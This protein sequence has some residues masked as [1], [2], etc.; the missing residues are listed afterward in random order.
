M[1]AKTYGALLIALGLI[2]GSG[3]TPSF[4]QAPAEACY[5]TPVPAECAEPLLKELLS[6]IDS[7]QDDDKEEP[8]YA[9]IDKLI[10]HGYLDSAFKVA[11]PMKES[12]LKSTKLLILGTLY[13][14][15]RDYAKTYEALDLLS[16]PEH[17]R[18]LQTSIVRAFVSDGEVEPALLL[19]KEVGDETLSDSFQASLVHRF[20]L[21][22]RFELAWQNVQEINRPSLRNGTLAELAFGQLRERAFSEV[23]HTV[24]AIDDPALQAQVYAQLGIL[25]HNLEKT[26]EAD[27]LFSKALETVLRLEDAAH[28][29]T[30]HVR[31]TIVPMLQGSDRLD[32][33]QR[34]AEG[35]DNPYDRLINLA[36]IA[37]QRARQGEPQ[38]ARDLFTR[39]L[40]EMSQISDPHLR[41][42]SVGWQA[43]AMME[44]GFTDEALKVVAQIA[45]PINKHNAQERLARIALSRKDYGLAEEILNGIELESRR[46]VGLMTMAAVT[47]GVKGQ[48]D[49]PYRLADATQSALEMDELEGSGE[50]L[51]YLIEV[52]LRLK[53]FEQVQSLINWYEDPEDRF[54]ALSKLGF[55]TA[56]AGEN[57]I[58][59]ET[60]ERR[61]D[62]LVPGETEWDLTRIARTA[63]TVP[64]NLEPADTVRL[65]GRLDDPKKQRL[66]LNVV[67]ITLAE[68]ERLEG[69]RTLVR[70]AEDPLL[71]KDFELAELGALLFQSLDAKSQDSQVD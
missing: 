47:I 5:V 32:P 33:A 67:A 31:R 68:R 11:R 6:R 23:L 7:L 59:V 37:A 30:D 54:R 28:E 58:A 50:V 49:L 60:L 69:A 17:K 26:Q 3:A 57:G 38:K 53:Q 70:L 9:L 48:E 65:S 12:R 20:V 25:A 71:G 1:Q 22:K 35:I 4:A 21:E 16:D 42:E 10:Q 18:T 8:K 40:A 36:Q 27:S 51:N 55:A 44:S 52:R 14:D 66:F 61:L 13:A 39:N 56:E 24:A 63:Q 62:L 34:V 43:Q 15:Q 41:V 46:L 2:G 45:N 19:V 64:L 29:N